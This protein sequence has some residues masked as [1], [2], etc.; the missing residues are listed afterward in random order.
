MSLES[1]GAGGGLLERFRELQEKAG[2]VLDTWQREALGHRGSLAIRAGRQ[3]GK[4]TV[5]ARKAVE[6]ALENS[7]TNTLII[8]AAQRQS[9]LLFEKA[10]MLLDG[11]NAQVLEEAGIPAWDGKLSDRQN[12]ERRDDF[13]KKHGVYAETPTKTTIVLKNGSKI[14]SL[15]SGKTGYFIRGFTLDLLIADEAAY[16]P[17]IVWN[18]VVPMTAISSKGRGL[19][20]IILLSTPF[21]KGGYFYDA[22]HDDGF[23]Q[24]HIS[25][26]DCPRIS[27]EFLRKE[28]ARMSKLEY[29]QEYQGEFVDEFNQLFPT[30]LIRQCADFI[31]WDFEKDYVK[32]RRYY[33]GVDIARYGGDENAFV[34]SEMD[35]EGR[36]RMVYVETTERKSI[37]DT[38]GRILKLDGR[39]GFARVFVDD[40]GVGGGATDMLMEKIG[41]KVMGLNNASRTVDRDG[42]TGRILKE[43]LYSNALVL[44]EQGKL[45]MV[46]NLRLQRS[47]KSMTF[48]YT[49]D[50][51]VRI[52]GAYSHIAEA[53]VRA[54]W[55]VKTKALRLYA[56]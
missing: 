19:G 12:M 17:E 1:G 40:G 56:L 22:F 37:V 42:R 39:F 28:K 29:A 49:Q 44:M 23:R 55:C 35:E 38:I 45:K 3:V 9:S 43:D 36:V 33:L 15:P 13:S 8:A 46:A 48:E 10:K 51:N 24:F 5:I 7:G 21:G 27:R 32:G 54:A 34:V 25:S 11:L 18:A 30:Q 52:Y 16:I 2:I 31:S 50:K 14:Y 41:R 53:F 47:L 26:E 6:F 20:W 4:S